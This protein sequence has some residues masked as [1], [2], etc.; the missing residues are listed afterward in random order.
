MCIVISNNPPIVPVMKSEGVFYAVRDMLINRRF[1]S[2]KFDPE[3]ITH[4]KDL[5]IQIKESIKSQFVM[6]Q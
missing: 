6:I 1:A 4:R 3:A 2:I 5:T